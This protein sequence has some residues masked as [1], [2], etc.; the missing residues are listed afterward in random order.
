[1]KG[2]IAC[3]VPAAKCLG[4]R[5]QNDFSCK[6]QDLANSFRIRNKFA[7]LDTPQTVLGS[8][9]DPYVIAAAVKLRR[10]QLGLAASEVDGLAGLA[11]GYTNK[12]ENPGTR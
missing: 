7:M 5:A 12:L 10:H 1:M 6:A 8:G 3:A 4:I 2:T 11:E 9:A